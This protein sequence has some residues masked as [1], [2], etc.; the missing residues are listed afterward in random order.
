M[1]VSE[2]RVRFVVAANRGGSSF[3]A[4]CAEFGI[5]RPTGYLWLERYQSGGVA[6]ISERSRR[7]L[8]SPTRT[9]EWIE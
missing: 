6:L 8:S 3:S 1:D 7:P 2:Q 4:L 5:T 9:A